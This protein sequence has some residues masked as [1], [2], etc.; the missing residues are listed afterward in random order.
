[1]CSTFSGVVCRLQVERLGLRFGGH[2]HRVIV[3]LLR[4][5][6]FVLID[7]ED[8]RRHHE[9]RLACGF[10]PEVHDAMD[11]VDSDSDV[12]GARRHEEWIAANEDHDSRMYN[13]C[14]RGDPL[15]YHLSPGLAQEDLRDELSDYFA[16]RRD[17]DHRSLQFPELRWFNDNLLDTY[18]VCRTSRLTRAVIEKWEAGLDRRCGI[19]EDP[20]CSALSNLVDD[21]GEEFMPPAAWHGIDRVRRTGGRSDSLFCPEWVDRMPCLT[22]N[23]H[24]VYY[25][26]IPRAVNRGD[27][28][29][30]YGWD[31]KRVGC[32]LVGPEATT[33]GWDPLPG[34]PGALEPATVTNVNRNV[35]CV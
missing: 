34:L 28:T 15:P 8:A 1:M 25:G 23:P 9:I 22:M 18:F 4:Q 12:E 33:H 7:L 10:D 5:A 14:V 16:W 2:Q 26:A 3:R 35:C 17:L 21:N 13:E 31:D 11:S 6:N 20:F 32:E 27:I 19:S 29:M 24:S 30:P